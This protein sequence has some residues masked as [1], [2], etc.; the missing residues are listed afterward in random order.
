MNLNSL[1]LLLHVLSAT[2]WVG[3][4]Y[5]AYM[6]LRPVAA[7]QLDPPVRLRLWVGVFTK[8]FPAVWLA[9]VLLP[10]TGYAMIFSI[11]QS[12]EVTPLYVHSMNGLGTLMLLI[13]MYVYFAPFSRLKKAVLAEQWPA[14][15]AALAQIRKLIALNLLLG[16]LVIAVAS[17]G[18]YFG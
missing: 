9:V 15:G 1:Y 5:F 11:W 2:I 17:G 14:G 6:C 10:V 12:M 18:R 3:G 4:M 16:L 7:T 8:F 13:Y